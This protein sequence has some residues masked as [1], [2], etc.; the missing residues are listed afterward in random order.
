MIDCDHEI[1]HDLEQ[2]LGGDVACEGQVRCPGC[3]EVGP[4]QQP[5]AVRLTYICAHAAEPARSVVLCCVAHS[6]AWSGAP[7]HPAISR[8]A[9]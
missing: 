2:H 3:G 8:T 7:D 4:C 5:A 6:E 1:D 9:L